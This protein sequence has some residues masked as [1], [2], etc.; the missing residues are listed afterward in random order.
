MRKIFGAPVKLH[1]EEQKLWTAFTEF[2]RR[3]GLPALPPEYTTDEERLGLRYLVGYN[4][5]FVKTYSN[6]MWLSQIQVPEFSLEK[7][8]KYMAMGAFYIS[9]RMSHQGHQPVLHIVLNKLKDVDLDVSEEI[10]ILYFDWMVKNMMVPGHVESALIVFDCS[11]L[12]ITE[13]PLRQLRPLFTVMEKLYKGRAY[14]SL[15]VNASWL[16]RGIF[17]VM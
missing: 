6:L 13:I 11:N 1:E 5:N 17:H 3:E 14:A 16:L 4:G 15:F 7:H 2:I 10:A 9:G 8:D 12:A